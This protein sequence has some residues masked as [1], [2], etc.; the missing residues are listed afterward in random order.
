MGLHDLQSDYIRKQDPNQETLPLL[1]GAVRLSA[2]VIARD[3]NQ[4][5]LQMVG[6]LL[7][8]KNIPTIEQF[9]NSLVEG[10]GTC[11]LRLLQP[12][13]YPPGG[14]VV[15]ILTGHTSDVDAVAVTPDGQQG[16]SASKDWTLKMWD[17][18]NGRE[19]RT[20]TGHESPVTAVAVTPDGQH[21]VSASRDNRVR[22][23]DLEVGQVIATFTCD[24][25]AICVFSGALQVIA[26]SDVGGHVYVLRLEE[27]KP[28]R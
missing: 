4:F 7:P 28:K 8:Y 11:C 10:T 9:S 27:P 13:L 5:A 3:R 25:R 24:S 16:V 12:A 18:T 1:R 21:G 23:F 14:E 20:L 2:H 15:R 22:V 19:L 26:A 6:R 17:L